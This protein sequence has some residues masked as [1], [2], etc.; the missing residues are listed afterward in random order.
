M[1]PRDRLLALAVLFVSTACAG[2]AA[3]PSGLA[4]GPTAAPLKYQVRGYGTM[5]IDTPMG[6]MHTVD[7]LQAT[8]RLEIGAP[9]ADG[10]GMTAVFEDLMAAAGGD[11]GSERV[12]GGE[13]IGRQFTG[14][15]NRDGIIEIISAPP[16]PV[17]LSDVVDPRSVLAELLGPLPADPATSEPWPVRTVVTAET[18]VAIASTFEGTARVVGD[19]VWNGQPAKL[20]VAEGSYVAEGS[21]MPMGAPGEITLEMS[22]TST[23]RYIWDAMRGVMLFA[24]VTLDVDGPI[25]VAAMNM[26]MD[27]ALTNRQTVELER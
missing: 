10:W 12:E 9:T 17:G 25:T 20:I 4:F 5:D 8:V 6:S 18:A 19:T 23:R 26:S 7:T 1:S 13:L 24:E 27:A 15:L 22:G 14:V 11:M 21:G 2:T 3:A 16:I